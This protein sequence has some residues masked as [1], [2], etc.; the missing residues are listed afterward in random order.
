MPAAVAQ[1]RENRA[2]VLE[3]LAEVTRR[4]LKLPRDVALSIRGLLEDLIEEI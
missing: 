2:L 3:H 1:Q 4:G